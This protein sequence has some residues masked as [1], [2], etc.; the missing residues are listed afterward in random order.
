L[1]V[2]RNCF[3]DSVAGSDQSKTFF[4]HTEMK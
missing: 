1:F 3:L 4:Q 2:S